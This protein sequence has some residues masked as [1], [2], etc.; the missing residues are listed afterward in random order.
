MPKPIVLR[1]EKQVTGS[2]CNAK[3]SYVSNSI[4]K[5]KLNK[6]LRERRSK[7]YVDMICQLD[8]GGHVANQDKVKQII[9]KIKDE[10]LEV[11]ISPILLGIV[12]T[13]YLEKPYEVHTLDMDEGVLEHYKKGQ[14][15]PNGMERVR[16]IA[17][18]GEY[19]FIEVYTDCYRAIMK[20]GT[21]AVVPF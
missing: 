5:T 14:I 20:D 3:R 10:F 8:A 15:L 17:M 9:Q 4:S 7:D 21:V 12:A 18:R 2:I 1:R 6:L 19:A 11:D 16:G 13:C